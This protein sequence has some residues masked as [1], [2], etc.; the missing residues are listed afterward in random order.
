M[1]DFPRNNVKTRKSSTSL[2]SQQGAGTKEQKPFEEMSFVNPDI[3]MIVVFQFANVI[4]YV[5]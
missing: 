3:M 1:W 5:W 4:D 2:W